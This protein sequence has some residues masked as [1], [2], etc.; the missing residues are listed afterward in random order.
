MR[1][2]LAFKKLNRTTSHRRALRRNLAQSLFEHGQITTTLPKAKDVQR[3]TEKLITLAK[4]AKAGDL[5]ARRRVVSVMTDR[6]VISSESENSEAH[7][8]SISPM[9]ASSS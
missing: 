4:K 1:H 5:E 2:R 7:F 8:R 3:L 9:M 6:A